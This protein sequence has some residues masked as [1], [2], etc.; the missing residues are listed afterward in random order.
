MGALFSRLGRADEIAALK[1]QLEEKDQAILKRDQTILEKD[2]TIL[3]KDQTIVEER[4]RAEK[5][6]QLAVL[7]RPMTVSAASAKAF[8]ISDLGKADELDKPELAALDITV[9][10]SAW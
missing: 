10:Q 5:A 4:R 9:I 6:E 3:K 7:L 8:L 2:Q 1:Q